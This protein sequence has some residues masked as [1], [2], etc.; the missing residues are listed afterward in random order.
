MTKLFI[1]YKRG[2]KE[3]GG[4]DI[5][6]D[7]LQADLRIYGHEV[8]VDR[9]KIEGGTER[10]AEIQ[11]AIEWADA[12]LVV[13]TPAALASP[14]V[15]DEIVRATQ[16]GK[17]LFPLMQAHATLQAP[18]SKFQWIDF[19]HDFSRGVRDLRAVLIYHFGNIS[20]E[21]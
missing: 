4:S 10:A 12:V 21:T 11:K 16:L 13:V 15:A 17:P 18:L 14:F 7:D 5:F 9:S 2:T 19:R 6:V 8:W 1:S 20:P 3:D